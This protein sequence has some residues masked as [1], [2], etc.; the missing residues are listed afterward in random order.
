MVRFHSYVDGIKLL[1]PS[2][3]QALWDPAL[4]VQPQSAAVSQDLRQLDW[5]R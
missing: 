2:V 3:T 4:V 5:H 1:Y